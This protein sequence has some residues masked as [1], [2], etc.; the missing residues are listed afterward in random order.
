MPISWGSLRHH[1]SDDAIKTNGGET[2]SKDSK[3]T[4]KVGYQ[5]LVGKLAVNVI[6]HHANAQQG[7]A[8]ILFL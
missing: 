7:H 3:E 5:A 1:I 8:G 4:G 6:L 2:E